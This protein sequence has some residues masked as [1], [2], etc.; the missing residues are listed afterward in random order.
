MVPIASSPA[1]PSQP[2]D[3]REKSDTDYSLGASSHLI[4]YTGPAWYC[5]PVC[6]KGCP[7]NHDPA[8]SPK[9][10]MRGGTVDIE[11]SHGDSLGGS[12]V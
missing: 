4:I 7:S 8:P 2:L 3:G 5:L 9:T 6:Y 10:L 11:M 1:H 12:A